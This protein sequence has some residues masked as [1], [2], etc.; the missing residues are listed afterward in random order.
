MVSI[1]SDGSITVKDDGRG[2]PV[3]IHKGEKSAAEVIIHSYTQ[4][5]N[6]IMTLIKCLEVCM[7]LVFCSKCIIKKSKVDYK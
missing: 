4:E 1:N 2:I 5:V 3:D 7:E 6:L